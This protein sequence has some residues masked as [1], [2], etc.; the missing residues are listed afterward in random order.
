MVDD[1]GGGIGLLEPGDFERHFAIHYGHQ[2]TFKY[3]AMADVDAHIKTQL[4]RTLLGATSV[5]LVG[6]ATIVPLADAVTFCVEDDSVHIPVSLNHE[7]NDRFLG[8]ARNDNS[9]FEI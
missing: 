7:N 3:F 4:S 1:V 8:F 2:T 6:S 9:G 5:R